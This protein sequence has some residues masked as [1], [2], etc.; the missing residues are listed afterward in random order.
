MVDTNRDL[1]ALQ[2]LLADNTTALISA[3][4]VRD[5]LVSVFTLGT[6][7]DLAGIDA[8]GLRQAL[9]V[10]TD[11]KVLTA[12]AASTLGF[13]W[14]TAGAGSHPDL[15]THDALGL[16]TDAELA[17]HAAAADPHTG[18]RLESADHSHATTGLQG[19]T[20][21]HTALTSVGANDHH[22][23]SHGNG[24]HTTAFTDDTT[25]NAH[26]ADTGDAH[27]ASAVSVDSTTLVGTGTDVQAVFEEMDNDIAALKTPDYL[28]GT[29]TA[30]LSGEI[31]VGTSPGGE[32][33]G[34]WASPTVDATHSGSAHH[35]EAHGI[36]AHTAHAN[37]KALYTDGSGDE[38][39]LSLGAANTV[40][41]SAGASSAP[42]FD[43]VFHELTLTIE[44]PSAS[45]N[46][47]M[48]QFTQAVTITAIQAAVLG[49][50]SVTIDPEH[51]STTTTATKLLSAAESVASAS[52]T[53]EHIGG[54]GTAM[55][56]SFN[57]ATLAAGDFLRLK[58]TAISGSP[59][60]L[61]VTIKWRLT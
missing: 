19:G 3:Q 32:L 45:D 26:I 31:V 27:D 1:A 25:V 20:V 46:V 57:D 28:V 14:E 22:N 13:K 54:T 59:T 43:Y 29:A 42:T 38:Q 7:G 53:G 44:N 60:Q 37:W 49:G 61:S 4:D 17:T 15:A 2:A 6:K 50:T 10:G 24:D 39:E 21:A 58:T 8:A 55:A 34:T 9:N 56:A 12:D 52:T 51:G 40:Y 35:N 11:G 36:A 41:R 16:A 23:Q 30:T 48:R 5:M 33:G 18:Y 47:I